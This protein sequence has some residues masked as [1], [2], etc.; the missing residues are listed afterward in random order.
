MQQKLLSPREVGQRLGLSDEQVRQLIRGGKLKAFN[1]GSG[2]QRARY[3]I[4]EKDI[5]EFLEGRRVEPV[6]VPRR[7]RARRGPESDEALAL[8]DELMHRRRAG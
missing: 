6:T 4:A 7:S 8:V 3:R 1:V 5:D 2:K